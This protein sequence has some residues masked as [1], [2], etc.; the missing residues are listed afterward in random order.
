MDWF[1]LAKTAFEGSTTYFD[2]NLRKQQE[3][4]FAHFQGRHTADSKY[5]LDSWKYRS[6]SFV[7]KTRSIVRKGEATVAAAFF[8]NVD[9]VTADAQDQS[10]TLQVAN[11]ALMKE[12]LNYR[13]QKSIPWFAT[14]IGAFQEAEVCGC[15]FLS[16]LDA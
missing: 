14:L 3:D 12:L 1:D 9:V 8:S 13:L 11:A 4:N 10:N 2:A 5:H 6:K 16:R 15:V 7:P